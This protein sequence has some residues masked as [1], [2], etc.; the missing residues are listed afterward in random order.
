MMPLAK[1]LIHLD[2]IRTSHG[3]GSENEESKRCPWI[4]WSLR[5]VT[6]RRD[7]CDS[8]PTSSTL[9]LVA[10]GAFF[11]GGFNMGLPNSYRSHLLGAPEYLV[12]ESGHFFCAGNTLDRRICRFPVSVALIPSRIVT[13]PTERTQ[14]YASLV[15]TTGVIN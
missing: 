7:Y 1:A 15:G 6:L 4:D 10:I 9:D 12:A 11:D 8:F 13:T 14:S 2:P 3:V 5:D